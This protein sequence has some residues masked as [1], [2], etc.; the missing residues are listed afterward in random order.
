MSGVTDAPGA[1]TEAARIAA[2][3]ELLDRGYGRATQHVA[4]DVDA[5][6]LEI[7]F[8]WAPALPQPDAMPAIDAENTSDLHEAEGDDTGTE[9]RVVWPSC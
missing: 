4:G 7:A 1:Q 5:P 2:M 3:R 8:S 9:I 6:P